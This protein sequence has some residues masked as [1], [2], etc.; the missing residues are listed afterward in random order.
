[1]DSISRLRDNAFLVRRTQTAR[2]FRVFWSDR[3][4]LQYRDNGSCARKAALSSL[5][6]LESFSSAAREKK[7]VS[8]PQ[9]GISGKVN[10]LCR[11]PKSSMSHS[12]TDQ[13][14][15]P[16][17]NVSNSSDNNPVPFGSSSSPIPN[18]APFRLGRRG[19]L[20]LIESRKSKTLFFN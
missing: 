3:K 2:P 16:H 13:R 10:P 8:P 4:N 5:R 11:L 19:V 17:M 1:M 18:G 7:M 6:F 20:R 15:P 14:E 12:P 9:E